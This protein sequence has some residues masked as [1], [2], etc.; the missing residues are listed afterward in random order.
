[1]SG[2]VNAEL[3]NEGT[4]V[5]YGLELTLEKFYSSSYYFLATLSL[6]E[7]KYKAPDGNIYNTIFNGNYIV[8][9]LAGKEI[10][11]GRK[12]SLGLNT[13]LIF[14]G[15]NRTTPIDLE[16]SNQEGRA[17]YCQDKFLEAK[18]RDYFRWDIG[19]I[20]RKNLLKYSWEL[21]AD[22]QNLTSRKN[23]FTSYYDNEKKIVDYRYFPGLI[24]IINF[25][26]V[27]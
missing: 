26:I 3:N 12:S 17:I 6:Y 25:R 7:S 16:R 21:S 23:I 10:S 18:I 20:V 24:P 9:L 8:N 19:F 2:T 13:K 27:F 5:N 14:K 15:G 22:I 1:M 4:A 11:L